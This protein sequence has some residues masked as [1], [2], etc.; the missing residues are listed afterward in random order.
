LLS[1][2]LA[3]AR[4]DLLG[5]LSSLSERNCDA[6]RRWS[7]TLASSAS[8]LVLSKGWQKSKFETSEVG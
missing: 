1:E 2:E 3:P 6:K 5:L 4:C 7:L 8:T